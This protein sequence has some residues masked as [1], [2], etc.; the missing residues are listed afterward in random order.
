MYYQNDL[1]T[2][3]KIAD[4]S[5]NRSQLKKKKKKLPKSKNKEDLLKK[6]WCGK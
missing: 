3:K 1:Q 5:D 2:I 4:V 6:Q